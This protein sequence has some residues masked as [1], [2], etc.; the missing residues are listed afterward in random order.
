MGPGEVDDDGACGRH[1]GSR[2]LVA[3]AEEDD[4]GAGRESLVVG[5][6]LWQGAVQPDVEGSGR[7]ACE[8]VGAE[9]DHVQLGVAE[10]AVERLL[11]GVA[12]DS[13]DGHRRHT[14]YYA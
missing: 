13:E 9:R 2:A 3:E 8:R 4:V 1:D 12:R 14:E 6:E 7:L 5:D 10:D 11:P